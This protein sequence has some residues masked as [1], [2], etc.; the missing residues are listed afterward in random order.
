MRLLKITVTVANVYYIYTMGQTAGPQ[1]HDHNS[2]K[3]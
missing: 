2:L 1:T 3:S